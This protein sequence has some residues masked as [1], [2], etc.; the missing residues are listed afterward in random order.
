[1]N[2]TVRQS[3]VALGVAAAGRLYAPVAATSYSLAVADV[4]IAVA[5]VALLGAGAAWN[6]GPRCWPDDADPENGRHAATNPTMVVRTVDVGT[7]CG[8][9]PARRS[10]VDNASFL[11]S[12]LEALRTVSMLAA[13]GLERSRPREFD[14]GLT[15]TGV[16]PRF[17]IIADTA[18]FIASRPATS[19]TG[20]VVDNGGSNCAA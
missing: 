15:G 19:L 18:R 4:C 14:N 11:S 2:F 3:A 5:A 16:S 9:M 13:G 6:L 8:S 10:P 20:D 1:M 7:K 17:S 12:P